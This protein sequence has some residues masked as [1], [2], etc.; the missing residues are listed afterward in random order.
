MADLVRYLTDEELKGW[1]ITRENGVLKAPATGYK[2]L[3]QGAATTLWCSLSKLAGLGGVYCEDCDIAEL[4]P[5]DSPAL[6]GVRHWAVDGATATALW[7]LS[8]Q[9]T[10]LRWLD[11]DPEPNH[12]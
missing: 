8:E 1:E 3:A 7:D 2:T 4:V 10:G 11:S 12:S 5:N 6:F 9:L